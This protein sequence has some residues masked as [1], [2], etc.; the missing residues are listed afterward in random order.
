M[1]LLNWVASNGEKL[2][3]VSILI[4]LVGGLVYICRHLYAEKSACDN[5]RILHAEQLGKLDGD[6]RVVQ[7]KIEVSEA[8]RKRSEER[9]NTLHTDVLK[10]VAG[11]KNGN[12]D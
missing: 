4:I 11:V 9:M 7:T 3:I 6:L 8:E 10:I 12:G 5:S 1:D 2:G